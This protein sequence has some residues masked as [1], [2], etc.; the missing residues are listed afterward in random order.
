MRKKDNDNITNPILKGV[1]QVGSF[2]EFF[3]MSTMIYGYIC[4]VNN[5][6]TVDYV[7][8]TLTRWSADTKMVQRGSVI[9]KD[10]FI[11]RVKLNAENSGSKIPSV[12]EVNTVLDMFKSN[13]DVNRDEIL[14][15]LN[16][17]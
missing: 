4:R 15:A 8:D 10:N 13:F 16:I 1:L 5:D 11:S 17:G 7:R 9:T 14:K 12:E 6:N 3:G 2:V